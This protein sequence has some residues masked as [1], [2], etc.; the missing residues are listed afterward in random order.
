MNS[1]HCRKWLSWVPLSWFS[2]F[3]QEI[4]FMYLPSSTKWLVSRKLH[5]IGRVGC[6]LS[7]LILK[8]IT[9]AIVERGNIK[10]MMRPLIPYSINLKVNQLRRKKRNSEQN[11]INAHYCWLF[12]RITKECNIISIKWSMLSHSRTLA[13]LIKVKITH[14]VFSRTLRSLGNSRWQI[15]HCDNH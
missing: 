7:S 11:I 4:V 1:T 6:Y 14:L 8:H 5:I 12:A 13:L 15:N 9:Q 3:L 10:C 2:F